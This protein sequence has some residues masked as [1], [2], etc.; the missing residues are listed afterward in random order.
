[1]IAWL[2]FRYANVL[3]D[4]AHLH[5]YAYIFEQPAQ[6]KAPSRQYEAHISFSLHCFTRGL[7]SGETLDPSFAYSDSRETRVFDLKRYE[8]SKMLREII[9]ALPKVKCYHTGHGN[10]FTIHGLNP[11]NGL[12]EAYE[13]YFTASRSSKRPGTLNLFIQ[14]A[15]VRDMAHAGSRPR[16]K[17]IGFFVIL[18]NTLKSKPIHPPI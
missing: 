4:L 12:P 18:H 3:Y 17:P 10:F 9:K 11:Q 2:P 6:G 16:Q 8:L 13:I 1:M 7:K 5:P 14:S 15:Y